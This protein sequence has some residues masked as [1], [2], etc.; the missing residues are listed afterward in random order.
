MET[1]QCTVYR[2]QCTLLSNDVTVLPKETYIDIFVAVFYLC[3]KSNE[4][5]V[6][7]FKGLFTKSIIV[8]FK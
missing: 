1:V 7:A 3:F 2:V 5:Y 6:Y 4:N 8:V